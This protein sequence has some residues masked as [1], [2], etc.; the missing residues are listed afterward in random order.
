M[1]ILIVVASSGIGYEA[2]KTLLQSG[3]KVFNASR[4]PSDLKG[5]ININGGMCF[6]K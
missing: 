1:N 3:H 6:M 2:A 5:I 4:T